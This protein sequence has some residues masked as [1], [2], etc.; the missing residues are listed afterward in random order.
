MIRLFIHRK[1]LKNDPEI[2]LAAPF[3]T[4]RKHEWLIK[5]SAKSIKKNPNFDDTLG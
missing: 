2:L 1:R 5:F 3:Y 4:I